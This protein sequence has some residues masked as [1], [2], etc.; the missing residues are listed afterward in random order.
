MYN[1][2]IY[3]TNGKQEN[4]GLCVSM[5]TTLIA[6]LGYEK[7]RYKTHKQC[8]QLLVIATSH[9]KNTMSQNVLLW[10]EQVCQKGNKK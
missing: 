4:I 1:G 10:T 9:D 3:Y 2:N 7:E 8:K 6:K 5:H